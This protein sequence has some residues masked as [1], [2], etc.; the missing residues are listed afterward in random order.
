MFVSVLTLRKLRF[1]AKRRS[2]TIWTLK[3]EI[4]SG[5]LFE[6][7]SKKQKLRNHGN[8][9][10]RMIL[11][12]EKLQKQLIQVTSN[13]KWFTIIANHVAAI[14]LLKTSDAWRFIKWSSFLL[15]SEHSKLLRFWSKNESLELLAMFD[16]RK[17]SAWFYPRVWC[18]IDGSWQ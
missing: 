4:I 14:C 6:S 12:H 13:S 15:T 18:T 11:K 16:C 3:S 7:C 10:T 5:V 1:C 2:T 8:S 9:T 17:N